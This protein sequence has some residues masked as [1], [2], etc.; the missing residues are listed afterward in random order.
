MAL[1][2]ATK[3]KVGKGHLLASWSA[4][5]QRSADDDGVMPASAAGIQTRRQES[6][7]G[8][9]RTRLSLRTLLHRRAAT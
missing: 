1:S 2:Q 3:H 6:E 5:S 9:W 4:A 8:T 7:P